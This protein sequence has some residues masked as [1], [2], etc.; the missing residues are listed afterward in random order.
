M[1]SI[2]H[3]HLNDDQLLIDL[4]QYG[5]DFLNAPQQLDRYVVI[6]VKSGKGSFKADFTSFT[7]TGPVILFATP[8][9]TIYVES[10]DVLDYRLL[11]F[12]G[13]FYCIEY[14][15][16]QVACNGLLFNNIYIDPSVKLTLS[17]SLI[18]ESLLDQM[19]SEIRRF[20][21]EEIVLRSYLQLLLAKASSIKI[22]DRDAPKMIA[23]TDDQMEHFKVL[24][25][26]HYL[27]HRRPC[28][29]AVMLSMSPNTFTKR[30]KAYFKKTPSIIIGERII[31]EA[32]KA[33]H[34]S[35]KSIKEIAYAL[36]FKDEF[37]FSRTFKKFTKVSPQHFRLKTGIS[38]VADL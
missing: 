13:D 23:A 32:K 37:Y 19:E 27:T 18:F 34:L 17:E 11:T 4:H 38:I 22:R 12:H 36:N 6:F 2:E 28:D 5:L 31:T 30:C 10:V 24:L 1:T 9:Q 29:Y 7:F 3:T 20:P 14:H 8:L 21:P 25:D 26:L 15:K 16:A 35:R 33:L